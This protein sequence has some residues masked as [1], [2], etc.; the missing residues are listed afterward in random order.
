[1][2]PRMLKR[3]LRSVG[4][5][6]S[7]HDAITT[8]LPSPKAWVA[9]RLPSPST[10]SNLEAIIFFVLLIPPVSA[11][12]V[13]QLLRLWFSAASPVPQ[14]KRQIS[15]TT[16]G[17]VQETTAVTTAD[18]TS[19]IGE[20]SGD[21]TADEQTATIVALRKEID[22]ARRE[23][24]IARDEAQRAVQ[25]ARK[26][27]VAS[28]VASNAELQAQVAYQ[29]SE[30]V[31]RALVEATARSPDAVLSRAS[32]HLLSSAIALREKNSPPNNASDGETRADPEQEQQDQP[33]SP[34]ALYTPLMAAPIRGVEPPSAAYGPPDAIASVRA[35]RASYQ[36]YDIP[37]TATA[38]VVT[39]APH[40]EPDVER[41]V[42]PATPLS[43]PPT[44]AIDA[45][46]EIDWA[47]V[48]EEVSTTAHELF[49]KIVGTAQW[50]DD[51]GDEGEEEE[52][53]ED[54][55][56]EDEFADAEAVDEQADRHEYMKFDEAMSAE[57]RREAPD[58]KVAS[59]S[60]RVWN[61][62]PVWREVPT[63]VK[64]S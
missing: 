5:D 6:I 28:L 1:M 17:D 38:T 44:P 60:R 33:S 35:A 55:D 61:A 29:A 62:S 23:A 58:G 9:T 25:R 46:P 59:P 21:S 20:T 18:A 45:A 56:E 32:S 41:M 36:P 43:E 40:G 51:N 4:V 8:L 15:L 30:A 24:A 22:A 48:R 19:S 52:D 13:L 57:G 39:P 11:M 53:E 47:A 50:L 7:E 3:L 64:E 31:A 26:E 63:P 12:L 34:T 42:T 37:A 10:T 2:P 27:H 16:S 54:E 14:P 49:E